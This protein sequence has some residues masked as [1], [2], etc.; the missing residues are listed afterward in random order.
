ML[1]FGMVSSDDQSEFYLML[2]GAYLICNTF[3]FQHFGWTL[4]LTGPIYIVLAAAEIKI[5]IKKEGFS[6]E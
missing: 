2:A 5:D 3:S 6:E 1:P 4:F